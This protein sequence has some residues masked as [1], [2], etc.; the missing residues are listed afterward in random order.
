MIP[1]VFDAALGRRPEVQI[2]G[3]DYP[4]PDGTC[5]RDYIHVSDLAT[6]HVMGLKAL[7]AGQVKSQAINLG[8]GKRL[9]RDGR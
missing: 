3:T 5:L 1:L 8:T 4:T 6:A 2:F 7:M 9:F